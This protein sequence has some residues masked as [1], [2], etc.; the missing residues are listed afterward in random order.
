M[1]PSLACFSSV[2][3][4]S[5]RSV[6]YLVIFRF[7]NV[8]NVEEWRPFI[9]ELV[10]VQ[11]YTTAIAFQTQYLLVFSCSAM[12]AL[13]TSYGVVGGQWNL[14]MSFK[15]FGQWRMSRVDDAS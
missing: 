9:C 4:S 6:L 2:D 15:P 10:P 7:C 12:F 11:L 3:V 1:P 13:A 5:P 14:S 8:I